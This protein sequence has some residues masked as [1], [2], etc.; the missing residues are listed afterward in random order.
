MTLTT[1]L[2]LVGLCCAFFCGRRGIEESSSHAQWPRAAS[3]FLLFY[4]D[5]SRVLH[6]RDTC[7]FCYVFADLAASVLSKYLTHVSDIAL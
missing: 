2:P 1:F 4:I 6:I 3:L 5:C 7:C